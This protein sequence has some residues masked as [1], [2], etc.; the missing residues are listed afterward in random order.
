M[1]LSWIRLRKIQVFQE[2]IELN[3]SHL[4]HQHFLQF[5]LIFL[6]LFTTPNYISSQFHIFKC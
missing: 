6:I 4:T 2:W 3:P 1:G 5:F